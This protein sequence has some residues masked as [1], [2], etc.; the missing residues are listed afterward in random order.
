[1]SEKNKPRNEERKG[2][3]ARKAG[4]HR[5]F[6]QSN[7]KNVWKQLDRMRK[8][9]MVASEYSNEDGEECF[10]GVIKIPKVKYEK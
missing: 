6:P 2:G 5:Q 1:M 7:S 4:G 9:S 3:S 10:V 8:S